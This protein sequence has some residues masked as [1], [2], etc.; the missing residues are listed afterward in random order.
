MAETKFDLIVLGGGPAGY[1]AAERAAHGGLKTMV[2]EERALGGV[3]LNEGCIPTK[4][5]LYSAKIYDYANHGEKYGV[6]VEGAKIDHAKVVDRKDKVVKTLVSGVG[7]KMKGAGVTVVSGTAKITG[8]TAS[9]FTVECAGETYEAAKLLICTGSEAVVPPIPG[10]RECYEGGLAVTNRE[11]LDIRVLPKRVVVVGGGVIGL[12]MA[13]YF[14][15][16]GSEVTVIEMLTKI[17]GPTDNDISAILEKNYAKKGVKFILGAKVASV[18]GKPGSGTVTYEKDGKS[19]TVD[20]DLVLVSTGRRARTAGIGLE[21]LGVQM[22]RGAIV[23]DDT[24][25][26]SVP[27]VWA[28]GD[29]NGKV[30]LAHTAYREGEAAVN[31]MLGRKDKVDYRAIPSVIYTNPEVGCVGETVESAKKAGIDAEEITMSL[32][33]SGRYIAENE[34]GDGIVKIVYGKKHHEILGV[35]MIGSYASEI[36]YGAAAMVAKC[37]RVADVQKIV[38]P[39]PT[40]CEVI[41]EAMFAIE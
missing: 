40:V 35:H 1:N 27:G 21:E 38:F 12:E 3:C 23:T 10:L 7:A 34:G 13:S 41:R 29:V 33:Y 5:L 17:A 9:G 36:I 11:I 18:S 4:T 16:V 39:H 20:C 15:S 8:K 31:D 28:A 19:E 37:Q 30:M 25:R 24:C 32:R 14:N 22:N 2:C 6:T 26:T